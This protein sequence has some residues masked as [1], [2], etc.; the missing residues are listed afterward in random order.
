MTH[1][2]LPQVLMQCGRQ[3]LPLWCQMGKLQG[4]GFEVREI[5]ISIPVL[6]LTG[7]VTTTRVWISQ[8]Q[9]RHASCFQ[10]PSVLIGLV[11]KHF[12]Y[13]HGYNYGTIQTPI[14][15]PITPGPRPGREGET[16]RMVP[17]SQP[18]AVL[19]ELKSGKCYLPYFLKSQVPLFVRY[20]IIL[21]TTI[22]E[23]CC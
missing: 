14:S 16:Q 15:H 4:M 3:V 21:R 17:T 20:T 11:I 8:F 1:S 2:S 23:R 9:D 6:P 7:H 19:L 12:K 18:L 5:Y 13:Q 22:K 10:L